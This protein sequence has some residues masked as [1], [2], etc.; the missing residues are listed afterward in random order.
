MISNLFGED[1]KASRSLGGTYITEI[2]I[3]VAAS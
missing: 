3:G 1:P 2:E